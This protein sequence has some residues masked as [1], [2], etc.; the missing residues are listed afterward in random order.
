MTAPVQIFIAYSHLDLRYKDELKKFLRPLLN[1]GQAEL[2]DDYDIEAGQDWEAEIKKR[3]YGADLILLLVSPDSLASDYFYGR[4]VAVSL[5]RHEHGEAMVVP[6][7]LRP[8]MWSMTPIGK[9][10]ALPTKAIPVTSWTSQDEAFNDVA[11]R[12]RAIVEVLQVKKRQKSEAETRRLDFVAG[13][14]AAANLFDNGRYEEAFHAYSSLFKLARHGWQPSAVAIKDKINHCLSLIKTSNISQ[15]KTP[16]PSPE[17]EQEVKNVQYSNQA[18]NSKIPWPKILLIILLSISTL[19]L[20]YY[21]FQDTQRTNAKELTEQK[22]AFSDLDSKYNDVVTQLEQQK[23][24]GNELD[25]EINVKLQ[26]LETEK[27]EIAKLIAGGKEY[28]LKLARFGENEITNVAPLAFARVKNGTIPELQAFIAR[29]NISETDKAEATKILNKQI[30]AFE[31]LIKNARAFDNDAKEACP[32]VQQAHQL[33][34]GD[35]RVRIL[36]KKLHCLLPI[37]RK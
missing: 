2:W 14:E 11:H 31:D 33:W 15:V 18:S 20:L 13:A 12:V 9:L 24:T 30:K 32:F 36:A 16:H 8:C 5:E 6:V 34:P 29:T 25:N 10:E 19:I 27:N 28:K 21:L 1:T 17:I 22:A 37:N 35:T 3:L 23:G 4:E 7:V 26:Q